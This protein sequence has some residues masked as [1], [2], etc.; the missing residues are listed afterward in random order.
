MRILYV[1]ALLTLSTTFAESSSS[2]V[3]YSAS[4]EVPQGI[5]G[6][7]ETGSRYANWDLRL[8]IG[9]WPIERAWPGSLAVRSQLG[10]TY[11]S[12][13]AP[14][15]FLLN[16]ALHIVRRPSSQGRWTWSSGLDLI[17]IHAGALVFIENKDTSERALAAELVGRWWQPALSFV[18][19]WDF[20]Q[21]RTKSWS[22]TFGVMIPIGGSL[23]LR[24]Y[25]PLPSLQS[26]APEF[27]DAI[28]DGTRAAEENLSSLLRDKISSLPIWPTLGLRHTWH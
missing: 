25:G 1:G 11:D 16:S 21:S 5:M 10:S 28:I 19:E 26:V 24:T 12:V 13:A 8:G 15:V 7:L 2:R 3:R 6:S 14:R 23:G 17:L 22:M 27:S 20:H 9:G 4:I 18:G